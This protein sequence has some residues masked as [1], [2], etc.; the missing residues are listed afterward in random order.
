MLGQPRGQPR[1][2][3]FRCGLALTNPCHGTR[4]DRAARLGGSGGAGRTLPAAVQVD[5]NDD[6]AIPASSTAVEGALLKYFTAPAAL[7]RW[8][9]AGL[10]LAGD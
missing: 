3:K 9:A 8:Q 4:R 7:A 1:V 2:P 6:D 10:E 5:I